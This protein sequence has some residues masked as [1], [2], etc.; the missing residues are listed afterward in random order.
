MIDSSLS[1]RGRLPV[2]DVSE[3][4][5][6]GAILVGLLSEQRR[7]VGRSIGR[8]PKGLTPILLQFM[9]SLDELKL[10]SSWDWQVQFAMRG[11]GLRRGGGSFLLCKGRGVLLLYEGWSDRGGEGGDHGGDGYDC[12]G[13]RRRRRKGGSDV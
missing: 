12:R 3:R 8:R 6:L 4:R 10:L 13:R 2:L 9:L 5:N 1:S 11:G 7:S